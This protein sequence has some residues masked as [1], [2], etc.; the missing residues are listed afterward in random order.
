MKSPF[1][2]KILVWTLEGK[3][4]P[5]AKVFFFNK[6]TDVPKS[7]KYV[8]GG[9]LTNEITAD[10]SGDFPQVEFLEGDYTL[11]AFIPI[12]PKEAYPLFPEDYEFR[13]SWDLS[14]EETSSEE[15]IETPVT[16][17]DLQA[18]REYDGDAEKVWVGNKL[19]IKDTLVY[20]T[21][22]NGTIVVS[23]ALTDVVWR[24]DLTG[25]DMTSLDWFG[26]D[27][28]GANDSTAAF[29][30]AITSIYNNDG[31]TAPYKLPR[32][33][34]IPEGTYKINSDINFTCPVFME[35]SVRFGNTSV[36]P[37]TMTFSS[38]LETAKGNAFDLGLPGLSPINL[39]FPNGGNVRLGW[40]NN[41]EINMDEHGSKINIIGPGKITVSGGNTRRI[42][43]LTPGGITTIEGSSGT[44]IIIDKID[45]QYPNNLRINGPV[46]V[47]VPVFDLS[48]L[49]DPLNI[50]KVTGNTLYIDRNWD[51]PSGFN[52]TWSRVEGKLV[53]GAKP[54]LNNTSG[55]VGYIG[56][57]NADVEWDSL[58]CSA[59]DL[60]W[61]NGPDAKYLNWNGTDGSDWTA[62]L[63]YSLGDFEGNSTSGDINLTADLT[64]KNLNHTG[65]F[66]GTGS[67][68]LE[69]SKISI[70]SGD[71]V[72][73]PTFKL[74]NSE[75][76]NDSP[77][78]GTLYS[79]DMR[80]VNSYITCPVYLTSNGYMQLEMRGCRFTNQITVNQSGTLQTLVATHNEVAKADFI[81]YH[82]TVTN[83]PNDVGISVDISDNWTTDISGQLIRTKGIAVLPGSGAGPSTF[84][85][86]G[87]LDMLRP[88][89]YS[90]A[91]N[92]IGLVPSP[93]GSY[94][95]YIVGS[96]M[97]L[98]RA[99]NG[100]AQIENPA[101]TE[102]QVYC[103]FWT[104]QNWRPSG[105]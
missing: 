104:T 74:F 39:R 85:A 36:L 46:T 63:A 20:Q 21:D 105:V 78:N 92:D 45:L 28:T 52:T 62:Q 61:T 4:A 87:F 98:V 6:G 37:I 2:P 35:K 90:W 44:T 51:I 11:K 13:D 94:R 76:V 33:L 9:T 103:N 17:G 34:Y 24:M 15:E 84:E 29:I 16:V 54:V 80:L 67:L 95:K 96:V 69:D 77:S 68:T 49:E 59:H 66:L 79:G 81:P 100:S 41:S 26:A 30:S 27:R 86:Y 82:F 70:T 47:K 8:E 22:N 19:F 12:D 53:N 5:K 1:N 31:N 71:N 18:L 97:P 7:V 64:L 93:F 40:F 89:G 42:G 88:D 3:P 101:Q 55:L 72:G 65:S 58:N 10:S 43:T 50:T 102:Q 38:G 57:P 32:T 75:V 48:W 83:F 14:G 99:P 25:Y 56:F 73:A 91:I 23:S 60:V